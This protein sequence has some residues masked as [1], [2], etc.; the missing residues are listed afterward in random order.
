MLEAGSTPYASPYIKTYIYTCMHRNIHACLQTNRISV[1][2]IFIYPYLQKY[3]N[4]RNTEIWKHL[5]HV[6][7]TTHLEDDCMNNVCMQKNMI[8]CM[9]VSGMSEYIC[10]HACIYPGLYGVMYVCMYVYI[11][12]CVYKDMHEYVCMNI[13]IHGHEIKWCKCSMNDVCQWDNVTRTYFLIFIMIPG[14]F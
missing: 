13:C 10:L 2:C 5:N 4:S 8:V 6:Y 11:Y 9:S 12:V 7:M 14:H 1:F 3:G